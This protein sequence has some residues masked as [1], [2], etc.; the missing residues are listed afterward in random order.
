MSEAAR[1]IAALA[2]ASG[3]KI[4]IGIEDD[5][6]VTGFLCQGASDI[7]EFERC[8][9]LYCEPSPAVTSSRV[10][11]VNSRGEHDVVLVLDIAAAVDRVIHRKSDDSVFLRV[12]DTSRE[13]KHE[14]ILALEYDKNQRVSKMR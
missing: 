3:G 7:N 12:N 11:V 9:I 4:V 10:E 1:H 13:L 6:E 8:H 2:N 14:Q 5:G